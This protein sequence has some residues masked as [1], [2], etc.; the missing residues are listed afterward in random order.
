MYCTNEVLGF[1]DMF[2]CFQPNQRGQKPVVCLRSSSLVF[3]SRLKCIVVSTKTS[4]EARMHLYPDGRLNWVRAVSCY[5]PSSREQRG[6]PRQPAQS[7]PRCSIVCCS[8]EVMWCSGGSLH[9]D[10]FLQYEL[11]HL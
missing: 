6:L 1:V 4:R 7:S 3:R 8:Q 5:P 11:F 9:Q 10:D 2:V